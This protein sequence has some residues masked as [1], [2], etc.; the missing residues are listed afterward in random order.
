MRKRYHRFINLAAIDANGSTRSTQIWTDNPFEA[1]DR[2]RAWLGDVHD[3]KTFLVAVIH[4]T[5][6][7]TVRYRID[8]Q[9]L[10]ELS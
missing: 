4:D 10:Q 9:S 7:Q 2:L 8:G 3:V 5:D 1:V 6:G